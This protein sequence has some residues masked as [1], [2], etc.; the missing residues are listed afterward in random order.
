MST[1]DPARWARVAA[2][3]DRI[4]ELEGENRE[5]ALALLD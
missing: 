3:F 1:A 5:A 4:V 2:E